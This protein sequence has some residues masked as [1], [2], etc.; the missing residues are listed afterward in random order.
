MNIN[1]LT[2]GALTIDAARLLVESRELSAK[3]LAEAHY[4]L[5]A[6]R[7]GAIGSFLTL[8]K[9]R[10]LKQAERIDRLAEKGDPLPPLAGVPVGIKDVLMTRGERTTAGSRFLEKFVAPYDATAVEKLEAAGAVVL[11]N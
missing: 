6:E 4:E 7:D 10:A 1:P 8:T 2:I 3:A 11:E 9:E 5:I